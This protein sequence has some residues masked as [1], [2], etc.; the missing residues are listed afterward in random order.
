MRKVSLLQ[1]RA[2]HR[3]A[4]NDLAGAMAD[5]DAA[6]AAA[7]DRADPF[8]QRSLN[9]QVQLVR[10]FAR[11][12]SGDQA[13]AEQLAAQISLSRPFSRNTALAAL[14][15][16]GPDADF[17]VRTQVLRRLVQLDPGQSGTYYF[18]IF[19]H[20]QF[21]AVVEAFG[22]LQPAV[23]P[24]NEPMPLRPRLL[25]EQENRMLA[26]AFWAEAAGR[27]AYALAALGPVR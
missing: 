20:G 22:A 23:R 9:L 7:L 8:Y 27:K 24:G 12:L 21:A 26:E 3:L 17:T 11:R 4:E 1:A 14:A 18:E 5:L 25:L 10:A 19:E 2:T 6:D 16:M 13:G 15:A